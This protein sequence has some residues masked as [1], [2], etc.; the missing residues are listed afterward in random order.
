MAGVKGEFLLLVGILLGLATT[1]LGETFSAQRI[2][3]VLFDACESPLY[4]VRILSFD[5]LMIHL[6]NF[7]TTRERRQIISY[8]QDHLERSHTLRNNGSKAFSS[9]RTS[10]S[11]RLPHDLP[12]AQ[13]ILSRFGSFQG[14]V[15]ASEV[16]NLQITAYQEGQEFKPHMDWGTNAT[17]QDSERWRRATTGFA[18][19][20]ADC[21]D[22]G[23]QFPRLPTNF[24]SASSEWCRVLDCE[25]DV[26][27]VKPVPGSVLFWVNTRSDGLVDRRMLHAGLP[28]QGGSKIGVNIWTKID[29]WGRP[30]NQGT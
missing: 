14:F 13:C 1:F 24:T 29:M 9:R 26:L 2:S 30:V 3:H 25:K 15:P 5:P 21:D 20:D 10:S 18:I 11:A 27:T 6:E 7:V 23:T 22:C 16:E 12:A 17:N 19:L 28:A 4:E 8:A